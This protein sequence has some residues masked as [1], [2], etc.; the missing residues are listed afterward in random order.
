MNKKQDQLYFVYNKCPANTDLDKLR[1]VRLKKIP[2]TNADLKKGVLVL[3][4]KEYYRGTFL[5]IPTY[6]RT[7]RHDQS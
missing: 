4:S 1:M 2:P 3:K 5:C 7:S 6:M